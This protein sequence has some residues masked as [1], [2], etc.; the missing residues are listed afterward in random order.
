MSED[1]GQDDN[2]SPL[3][4][5][6]STPM[7]QNQSSGYFVIALRL[8][9]RLAKGDE[10]QTSHDGIFRRR[11]VAIDAWHQPS[12]RHQVDL[13]LL[14]DA[15]STYPHLGSV[16][17]SELPR[18]EVEEVDALVVAKGHRCILPYLH[19]IYG[20]QDV[21]DLE[22]PSSR[23]QRPDHRHSHAPREAFWEAKPPSK[24]RGLQRL[25]AADAQRGN[26]SV[27]IGQVCAAQ[28]LFQHSRRDDVSDVSRMLQ[29]ARSHAYDP[30]VTTEN[31]PPRVPGV[32]GGVDLDAKEPI[33]VDVD[34]RN[35]APGD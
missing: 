18:D 19:A 7:L 35:H 34:A 30:A 16:S 21:V 27:A 32:D 13:H 10:D 24:S 1:L 22:L 26:A 4:G 33:M 17:A 14:L 11:I 12:L 28:E 15:M 5:Q 20:E 6:C 23:T 8:R 3:L 29:V 31:W 2:L 9:P 25:H